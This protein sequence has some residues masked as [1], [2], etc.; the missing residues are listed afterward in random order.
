MAIIDT[1]N[2]I[3]THVGEAYASLEEMG[4]TIP[5]DKNIENLADSI[6]TVPSGGGDLS[7]YFTETI[8]D[9][10]SLVDSG[11]SKAYL[12]MPAFKLSG[13]SCAYM[14]ANFHGEEINV[15]GL[16]TS[17][18][19]K[20]SYMFSNATPT[21]IVGLENLD[22]TNATDLTYMFQNYGK[23]TIEFDL[24]FN[25]PPVSLSGTS[26]GNMFNYYMNKGSIDLS[27]FN[28]SNVTSMNNLFYYCQNVTSIDISGFDFSKVINLSNMFV[29]ANSLV[30]L[31]FGYN[32]GKGYTQK[33]SNY[34]N[35]TVNLYNTRNLSHD[36][37][38]SVINGLYDLNLT[39][40]VAGGGTLYRQ[41]LS[42]GSNM[43]KLT[44]EEI[45]IATNKGWN[46]SVS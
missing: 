36:S 28:I 9:G 4:A 7:Q 38:M 37:L 17:S 34:S 19:K 40:N 10:T 3:K 27:N 13:T 30:N 45:A 42:L 6:L 41:K 29:A 18:I 39:Y 16:D 44:S 25:K 14:F 5:E 32:L 2:N 24:H 33:T 22:L 8:S 21:R 11:W 15:S 20:F 35:Y 26:I 23:N 1:I 43:D 46:V 12:K 31:N